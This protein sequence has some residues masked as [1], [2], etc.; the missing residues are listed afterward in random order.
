MLGKAL[1]PV[2]FRHYL[3]RHLT[4]LVLWTSQPMGTVAKRPSG[5]MSSILNA[6]KYDTI[7]FKGFLYC[8]NQH[9]LLSNILDNIISLPVAHFGRPL[10]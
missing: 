2:H 1:F 8:S 3:L 4:T 9:M 10:Q 7:N 5:Q 6:S